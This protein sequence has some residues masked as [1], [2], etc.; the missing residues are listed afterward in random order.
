MFQD[1]IA[2]TAVG[3]VL[4][5]AVLV[6]QVLVAGAILLLV[7]FI[8]LVHKAVASGG[9]RGPW[10]RAS[11]ARLFSAPTA[12]W[13]AEA[14]ERGLWRLEELAGINFTASPARLL[15]GSLLF[16][17]LAGGLLALVALGLHLSVETPLILAPLVLL[18]TLFGSGISAWLLSQPVGWW[19]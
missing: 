1:E 2:S 17:G 9:A 3:L 8:A 5:C 12:R 7:A 14:Y 4:V 16:A 6:I 11:R 10:K 18:L 13:W 15:G 19:R